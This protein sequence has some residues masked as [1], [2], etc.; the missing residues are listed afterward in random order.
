M[1]F[2]N[3]NASLRLLNLQYNLWG[4]YHVGWYPARSNTLGLSLVRNSVDGLTQIDPQVGG[5]V[6]LSNYTLGLILLET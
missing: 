2:E 3:T 5:G 1:R 6:S 4:D